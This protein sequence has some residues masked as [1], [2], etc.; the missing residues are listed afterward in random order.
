MAAMITVVF[1]TL[2]DAE[3]LAQ[4]MAE[5]VPAA[6]DGLVREVVVADAGSTDAT[7]EVADEAGA[8]IVS[9]GLRSAVAVARA[10]WILALPPRPGL[11]PGWERAVE[12]AL[13]SR[14]GVRLVAGPWPWSPGLGVLVPKRLAAGADTL[15]A[16]RRVARARL[17]I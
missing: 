13:Q 14:V 8:T 17:R 7:L 4:A 9:G 11:V 15:A 10:D 16:L 1:A 6:V 2:N 5:L 3:G 12:R